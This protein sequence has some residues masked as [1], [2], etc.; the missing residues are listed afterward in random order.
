MLFRLHL[1]TTRKVTKAFINVP[2]TW[3]PVNWFA[4]K[5]I[6][7]VSILRQLW[8]K[9]FQK[10]EPNLFWYIETMGDIKNPAKLSFNK[11][12][13]RGSGEILMHLF[14]SRSSAF[15]LS[16]THT[17]T[18]THAH[19]HAHAHPHTP[20]KYI[21]IYIIYIYIYIYIHFLN[22]H[23]EILKNKGKKTYNL[24]MTHKK[25]ILRSL[26]HL[27]SRHLPVQSQKQKN[28]N[29]WTM[30]EICSKS[31]TIKRPECCH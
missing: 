1:N 23:H 9:T 17:H 5:I 24:T 29:T 4:Q 14:V 7:L 18:H 2:I 15:G 11:A 16:P 13:I 19:A 31:T 21:Y 26:R 20:H 30:F 3:K 27:P 28:R 6:W 8:Q 12:L 10:F 22:S 25:I